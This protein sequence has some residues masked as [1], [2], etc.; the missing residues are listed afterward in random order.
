MAKEDQLSG[1]GESG[2]GGRGGASLAQPP[3]PDPSKVIKTT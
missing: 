3:D 1:E 2:V